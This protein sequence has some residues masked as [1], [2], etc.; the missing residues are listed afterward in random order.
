MTTQDTPKPG[1]L[2]RITVNQWVAAAL[3]V[4]SVVFIAQNRNRVDINF[5]LVTVRSPMWLILLIM[6]LVG[7]L[8]GLLIRRRARR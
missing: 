1:L 4:L 7:A 3:V 2:S 5:L 8:A 6:F